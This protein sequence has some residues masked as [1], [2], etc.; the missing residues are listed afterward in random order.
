MSILSGLTTVHNNHP[1]VV[2]A[3]VVVV[4]CFVHTPIPV[5]NG[6]LVSL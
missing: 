3:A 2:V 1:F 5:F 6:M 4:V